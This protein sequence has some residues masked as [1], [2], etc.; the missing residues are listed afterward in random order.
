MSDGAN[1]GGAINPE[2]AIV[3]AK[4]NDIQVFSIGMGSTKKDA[5]GRVLL[6]EDLSNSKFFLYILH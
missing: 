3:Y 6:D 2:E 1:N 4:Q 5:Y